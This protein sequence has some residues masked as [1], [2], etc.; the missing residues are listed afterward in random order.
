MPHQHKN[1]EIKIFL[2]YLKL[3][4]DKRK[5][6]HKYLYKSQFFKSQKILKKYTQKYLLSSK[7][8]KKRI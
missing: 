8:K 5:I 7:N 3:D 6:I 1:M 2:G 4:L